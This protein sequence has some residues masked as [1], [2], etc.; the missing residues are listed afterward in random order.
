MQAAHQLYL[1]NL[2]AARRLV[3]PF[4][5]SGMSDEDVIA[6]IRLGAEELFRLHSE[7]DALLKEILFSK[8]AET[9]TAEEAGDLQA[10]AD[11]LFN[12]NRSPDVGIAY[13]IHQLLYR[14]AE[15]HSDVDLMVREL[16][17][18]GITLFYLNVRDPGIQVNL[19][20]EKVGEYFRAGAEYFAQYEQLQNPET[21]SFIIRCMGNIKYG[22]HLECPAWEKIGGHTPWEDYLEVFNYT[23]KVVQDPRY[24]EMDPGIPWDS[25]CYTLHYDR[26]QF[27]S[28]LR[29]HPNPGMAAAVLESAEYVYRHQEQIARAGEKALGVR[30]QYVYGAARYH[31]GKLGL[32]ELVEILFGICEGCGPE[33]FSG[34]G[35][36]ANLA[37]PEYLYWYALCLSP[38]KLRR[39]DA[40]L[41]AVM[42]RR[43]DYLFRLPVGDNAGQVSHLLQTTVEHSSRTDDLFADR[44]LRYILACHPPTFVHSE[45]VGCMARWFCARLAEVAPERL[46]G[47]FGFEKPLEQPGALAALLEQ[48]Y[49]AGLYHDAGK[50]M[51]LSYVGQY[52]RRL[53]DEEFACIKLHPRFGHAL[54]KNLGLPDHACAAQYHHRTYD[55]AGGYPAVSAGCPARAALMVDI[56]TVVDA[57]DA[58]TDNV[59][60]SY[61]AA[62]TFEQLVGELRAGKGTRYAPAVVELLDDAGFFEATR[63]HL[64]DSRRAAYLHA[65][66]QKT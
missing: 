42:D 5:E 26:T 8:T 13:R 6:A 10:L 39:L 54:L 22:L 66:R 25:F 49:R 64:D 47:L 46:D 30:T 19:F 60:R 32:E 9:L 52:S 14:Y 55:L 18:Q 37:A 15:L 12:F 2:A 51:L 45:V 61:A 53:L 57:L 4:F 29:E 21:R 43:M 31:A 63:R 20:G 65:Y 40:R 11:A 41:K 44:V 7:D 3:K 35:I 27:L 38:E 16:Y 50:S 48:A 56:I 58:G 17:Y 62:K 23:M 36:W 59:G 28:A 33:D 1:N 34:D 24:R